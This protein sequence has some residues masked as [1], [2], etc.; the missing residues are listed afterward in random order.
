[1]QKLIIDGVQSSQSHNCPR[2]SRSQTRT[3]PPRPLNVLGWCRN[4]AR[5]F[6]ED[7]RNSQELFRANLIYVI[8]LR[9]PEVR[10]ILAMPV[11]LPT[12]TI[13]PSLTGNL[14]YHLQELAIFHC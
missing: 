4:L 12:I 11:S 2:N 5:W 1:M 10:F 13:L 14:F 6:G 7:L 9:P 3:S 8:V